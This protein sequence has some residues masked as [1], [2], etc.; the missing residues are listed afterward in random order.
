MFLFYNKLSARKIVLKS[1]RDLR[2]AVPAARREPVLGRTLKSQE[3]FPRTSEKFRRPER[4]GEHCT[5]LHLLGAAGAVGREREERHKNGPATPAV[6]ATVSRRA[7][8]A[9]DLSLHQPLHHCFHNM[10]LLT[11]VQSNVTSSAESNMYCWTPV[12]QH[13]D[14]WPY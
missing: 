11:I 13:Y 6:G 3:G 4:R 5:S 14:Q 12:C 1:A 9:L 7:P 2:E 8:R 10:P